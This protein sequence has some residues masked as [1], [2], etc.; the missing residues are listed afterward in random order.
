MPDIT[1]VAPDIYRFE[2]PVAGM[3]KV[4]VTYLINFAGGALIEPGPAASAPSIRQAMAQLGM[5]GLSLIIPTHIH[6]DHAGGAGTLSEMFPGAAVVV[7]PRGAKHLVSPQR[8]IESTRLVWGQDFERQLGPIQPVPE[9]RLL[10]AG[11]GQ[12]VPLGGREL[13]VI[14]A[15]GHSPNHIAILDRHINGLFCGEAL[16]LSTCRL[17]AVA[18][19]SSEQDIYVSTIERLMRLQ[20]DLLFFS[21]ETVERDAGRAMS[22]ALESARVY[23]AMIL[24]AARRGAS[25][26]GIMEL[27]TD[28][29]NRRF[30]QRPARADLEILVGGYLIYFQSKGQLSQL[31]G[32]SDSSAA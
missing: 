28:D 12:I 16:G 32:N 26:E 9:P 14:H 11:D 24:E 6:V 7:H 18:P 3:P 15:L 5:K 2:A 8:L 4:P 17:P 10:V 22:R 20:P 1:E 25:Q 19:Y 29:V 30:G 31:P 23:S 27:V 21:H 13:Q